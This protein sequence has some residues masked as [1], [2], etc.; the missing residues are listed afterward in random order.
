MMVLSQKL[1]VKMS[2][3]KVVNLDEEEMDDIEWV[4]N[5][6][7]SKVEGSTNDFKF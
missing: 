5:E 4:V 2:P 1:A 3:S 7:G 6:K